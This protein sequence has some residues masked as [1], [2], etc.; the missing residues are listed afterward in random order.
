[1]AIDTGVEPQPLILRKAPEDAVVTVRR[2]L[3]RAEA[4]G[5]LF[6]GEEQENR[7]A[8]LELTQRLKRLKARGVEFSEIELSVYARQLL[9]GP[10][11]V[12]LAS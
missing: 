4:G 2:A 3:E 8:V 6:P 9:S 1:M 11:R 5:P 12:P 7:V 10:G